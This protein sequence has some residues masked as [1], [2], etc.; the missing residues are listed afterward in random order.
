MSKKLAGRPFHEA[1]DDMSLVHQKDADIRMVESILLE[2]R[3]LPENP[4]IFH[5]EL[6][7]RFSP[8]PG[9]TSPVID[10]MVAEAALMVLVTSERCLVPFYPCVTP[11]SAG[12]RRHTRYAPTHV[13][14]VTT[15]QLRHKQSQGHE[16]H[17]KEEDDEAQEEQED[18]EELEQE[19]ELEPEEGETEVVVAEEKGD[20]EYSATV[21]VVWGER[22]GLQVW[23]C[24]NDNDMSFEP[25]YHISSEVWLSVSKVNVIHQCFLNVDLDATVINIYIVIY[26]V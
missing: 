26:V 16:E 5:L 10:R 8:A 13:F 4:H 15:V 24:N 11:S 2:S 14:A 18:E 3:F 22:C 7:S 6:L 23:C 19:Q 12:V 1:L 17:E 25:L 21:A 20:S 9:A